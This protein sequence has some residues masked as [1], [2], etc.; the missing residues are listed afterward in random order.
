MTLAAGSIE[1]ATLVACPGWVTYH[2][3][4]SDHRCQDLSLR[5]LSC[6]RIVYLRGRP[7]R[8]S[9]CPRR[10]SHRRRRRR[11]RRCRCPLI[12]RKYSH[13]S[14]IVNKFS[15]AL[16]VTSR[17]SGTLPE[18]GRSL[19]S[20]TSPFTVES[21]SPFT[22]ESESTISIVSNYIQP[23]RSHHQSEQ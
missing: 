8:I 15:S 5:P 17:G 9:I 3:K 11:H 2:R 6:P 4:G 13:L 20:G 22:V 16:K 12:C 7:P 14:L 18:E 23:G 21:E 1:T 19:D 10:T